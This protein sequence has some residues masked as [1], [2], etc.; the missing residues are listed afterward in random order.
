MEVDPERTTSQDIIQIGSMDVLIGEDVKRPIVSNNKVVTSTPEV[1]ATANSHEASG[2]GS[3]S[4]YF[5]PRWCPPGLTRTQRRKLQRLSFS[6]KRE[7]ELEMQRD[8]AFNQY[9]TMVPQAKEWRVKASSQPAPARPVEGSVTPVRLVDVDGQTDD[10]ETPHDFSSSVPMVCD[11]KSASDPSPEDNEELVD[12][13]SPPERMNLDINVIHM[14]MD[15]YVLL[16]EHIAH[17]DF[18][19]KEAILQKPKATRNHMKALYMKG[20]INGK[21]ISRLLVD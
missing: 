10:P 3:N 15:G 17:H 21:P 5:L 7:K 4:K 8:E 14:S 1:F 19:P 18:G 12:Y 11:D 2:S 20:H 16:E 6:D 9:K 13:S